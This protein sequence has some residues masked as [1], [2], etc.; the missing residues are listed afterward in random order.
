MAT[1]HYVQQIATNISN[2]L[3]SD[4]TS[5]VTFLLYGRKA[6]EYQHL[7]AGDI[8]KISRP[9]ACDKTQYFNGRSTLQKQFCLKSIKPTVI[10]VLN[11]NQV[12]DQIG[13]VRIQKLKSQISPILESRSA[14]ENFFRENTDDALVVC[15]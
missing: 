6:V 10:D 9:Y 2:F 3:F 5:V 11:D 4:G 8:V 13:N 15:K 1:T 14:A 12:A 7:K